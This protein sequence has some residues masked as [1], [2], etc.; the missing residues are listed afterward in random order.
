MIYYNV[1]TFV[2]GINLQPF[3][4]VSPTAEKFRDRPGTR[5]AA[6]N[7]RDGRIGRLF[8]SISGSVSTCLPLLYVNACRANF[9]I[10]GKIPPFKLELFLQNVIGLINPKRIRLTNTSECIPRRVAPSFSCLKSFK[11]G[12][13]GRRETLW[14]SW[15]NGLRRTQLEGDIRSNR[16]DSWHTLF[17]LRD[18]ARRVLFKVTQITSNTILFPTASRSIRSFCYTAKPLATPSFFYVK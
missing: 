18:S 6:E 2:R 8:C 15:W 5:E 17:L 13:R 10:Q 4:A 12:R 9:T 11:L 7:H 14:C 3:E 1:F 16:T